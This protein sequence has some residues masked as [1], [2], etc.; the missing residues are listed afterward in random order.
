MFKT[1]GFFN[2]ENVRIFASQSNWRF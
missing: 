1:R 2:A